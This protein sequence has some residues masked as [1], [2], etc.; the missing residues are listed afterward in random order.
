MKK[1]F[2]INESIYPKDILITS[3]NDFKEFSEIKYEKWLL[4]IIW[5]NESFVDN[6]FNEFMNYVLFKVNEI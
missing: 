5:D 6:I 1:E 3:I 4:I 2:N